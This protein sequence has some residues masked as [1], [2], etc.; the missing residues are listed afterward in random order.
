MPKVP[1]TL[2]NS[3]QCNCPNCPTWR[4]DECAKNTMEALYCAKGVTACR[5]TDNG[6]ICGTCPVFQN[7]KLANGYF[8]FNGEAE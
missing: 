5:F 1:D 4:S 2:A 8:C 6:C 3:R 7:Y